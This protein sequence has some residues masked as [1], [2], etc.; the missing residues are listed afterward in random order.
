MQEKY[1]LIGDVRGLGAMVAM[2]LVKNRKTKEPAK[3]ETLS[4]REKC[5]KNGLI[6]IGAGIH[7]NVIRTLV[8]LVITDEELE[9]ALSILDEAVKSTPIS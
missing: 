1:P 3:K 8:P 2:E 6:V 5:Y 9:E 7:S 4:I